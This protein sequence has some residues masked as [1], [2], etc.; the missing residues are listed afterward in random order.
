MQIPSNMLITRI[1]PGIYMSSWMLIWAVVSACTGLVQNY[2]GMVACRFML[3]VTEAPVRINGVYKLLW[4][5]IAT[6]LSWCDIHDFNLLHTQGSCHA[7][8]T[9]ILRLDLSYWFLRTHRC[10]GL[11]RPR[12][13][14]RYCGMEV[15]FLYVCQDHSP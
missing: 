2:A 4:S 15:A 6:V 3:G 9:F 1:K 8:C 11:R 13:L 5:K 14:P 12:W 7:H 10:W